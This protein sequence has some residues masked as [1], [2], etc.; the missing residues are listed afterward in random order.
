M[1][2]WWLV[3]EGLNQMNKK[4]LTIQRKN[5]LKSYH[6]TG[7]QNY[8]KR[9]KN[10][11][12]LSAANSWKHECLKAKICWELL[13]EKK[14]FITEGVSNRSGLRHDII[15]LDDGV[16]FEVETDKRRAARFKGMEGVV[17]VMTDAD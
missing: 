10:A 9:P 16:I 12:Y 8:V 5:I 7:C 13:K 3:L 15:C 17:V 2:L 14:Q 11:V 1:K 6:I 4:D